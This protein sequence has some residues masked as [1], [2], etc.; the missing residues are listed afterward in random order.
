MLSN[1][2]MWNDASPRNEL[3]KW[4][5]L[6]AL[7][8]SAFACDDESVSPTTGG[9]GQ[10]GA[11]ATTTVT[12]AATTTTA[13]Q[14]GD[15]GAPP[16]GPTSIPNYF[17]LTAEAAG[18]D[19]GIDVACSLDFIFELDPE[20]S[21]TDALVEYPGTH[22][23]EAER[24]VLDENGDG[25]SFHADVFGEVVA[26]LIFEG[27]VL[28]L[29]IPIN[30]TT[31]ESFWQELAFFPGTLEADGTGSGTWTCAPLEI[32]QDG[33]VDLVGTVDGTWQ[34]EPIED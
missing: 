25:F 33:Y 24:T 34:I 29:E 21:R 5:V 1:I 2:F 8:T 28:E 9:G 22:G 15:G 13:G 17:R 6:T 19:Q 10:G 4:L 11:D 23:G 7:F 30:A 16:A 26:R 18:V 27:S 14:G 20:R 3:A 12:T 31:E 32:D